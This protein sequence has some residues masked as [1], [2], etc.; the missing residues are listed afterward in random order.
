MNSS[1]FAKIAVRFVATACVLAA[2]LATLTPRHANAIDACIGTTTNGHGID[3]AD[4]GDCK[5]MKIYTATDGRIIV[6]YW[7]N[8]NYDF[9]QL[10]W[11]RADREEKQVKPPGSG[12]RGGWW[13]LNNAWENTPYTFKVQACYSGVFGSDCTNWKV[14][15][16]TKWNRSVSR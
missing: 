6:K 1:T 15:T 12:S 10:R 4:T 5:Y 7:G 9:Y 16:Y 11:S 13:A 8:Q 2:S 3:S 14:V